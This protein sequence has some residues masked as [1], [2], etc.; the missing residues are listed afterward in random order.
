MNV[1]VQAY[2]PTSYLSLARWNGYTYVSFSKL[3]LYTKI[4]FSLRKMFLDYMYIVIQF[5]F[6]NKDLGWS[7]C[8]C[9]LV[10][11]PMF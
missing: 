1:Y 3:E 8:I 10:P 11:R 5:H 4:H 2:K 6:I 9:V 7:N